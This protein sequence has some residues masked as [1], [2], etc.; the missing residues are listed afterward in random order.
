MTIGGLGEMPSHSYSSRPGFCP[1][2]GHRKDVIEMFDKQFRGIPVK[3]WIAIVALAAVS[4]FITMSLAAPP[5]AHPATNW[6]HIVNFPSATEINCLAIHGSYLY[7]AMDDNTV[8]KY[9]GTSWQDTSFHWSN[10]VPMSLVSW[11]NKLYVGTY[12]GDGAKVWTY[13][14]SSWTQVNTDGFGAGSN[15]YECRSLVSY[16]SGTGS[17]LYALAS[18]ASGRFRVYKYS[19]AGTSWTQ[20]DIASWSSN[21]HAGLC[22][23][24]FGGYLW[25]GTENTTSGTEIWRYDGASWTQANSNGFGSSDC[26]CWCLASYGGNLYASTGNSPTRGKVYRF[27][28]GTS[29]T[30]VSANGL[31]SDY[32]YA[33]LSLASFSGKLYAGTRRLN[34]NPGCEIWSYNGSSWSQENDQG[35]GDSANTDATAMAVFNSQLYVGTKNGNGAQIWRSGGT[36]PTSSSVYL[37]EGT[38]DWGFSEYISIENPN[39]SVANVQLTYQTKGGP[40]T[41][42]TIAMPAKSQATV[43]PRETVGNT[44]FSTKVTCTNGK[45]I[46]ADR[47]MTWNAGSGEE[48]HCAVAVTSPAKTWYLAEGSSAWGFECWLLIQNPGTATANCTLTYM[49]DG[50][51]P[52][53]VPVQVSGGSRGTWS[54]SDQIGARDAS[55][56]VTSDQPIIAERAMYRNGRREGHDS[57]G[58]TDPAHDYYLAEGA[59]GYNVGYITYVLVQNP[60]GSV[61]DVSLTYMTGTGQVAG[62]NFQMPAN[63]RK[64][65]RVNDQLPVNTD[66][67][68]KVHG[69]Q[70]IIAERAMY[71]NNGTGEACHDSIGMDQAHAIFYLPD[72]DTSA[73]RE[74]WT[75]VQ[76]PNSSA[77]TV[78][79]S[80]LT[81]NGQGNVVKTETIPQNSRRTFNMA[82]HSGIN[83]RASIMVRCLTSGKKIMVERAMYWNSRGAGTDTIGGYSDN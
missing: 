23:T 81:P 36:A 18:S 8:R 33:V 40:K 16:D 35:F 12:H 52:I 17:E 62:P 77:V 68:T 50:A 80:Y 34:N 73:G 42:P 60:N 45:T 79:I 31:G 44:D 74:T 47:T 48:G 61:A 56:K 10:G 2:Y 51:S 54:M 83:G 28:S 20:V 39:T 13:N 26:E 72:G 6:D 38:T 57:T 70:P 67:S 63:S 32:N 3:G 53:T 19:G 29:W 14:G 78:E 15:I 5:K 27:N 55:I 1:T 82:S 46:A 76:N 43:N 30:K 21:N 49:I 64:T 66:V 41:G 37:A 9:N 11:N 24:S 69:S 7:I 22:A 4:L 58:T 71:W 75:L 25:I 65:I 59:I